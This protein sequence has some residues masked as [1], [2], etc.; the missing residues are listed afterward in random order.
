MIAAVWHGPDDL[1]VEERDRPEALPGTVVVKVK[2]CA[3]CGSDLRILREGNAR[4]T[5]PRIIGHEIA[6]EVV[7]IGD[8]VENF[9]L[10]D[11]ISTGADVPCGECD[12][13]RAGLANSCKILCDRLSV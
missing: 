5:E 6:G 8:G 1:R 4:I 9:T 12:Y 13:C 7:E 10:N 11:R 3:V 2:A